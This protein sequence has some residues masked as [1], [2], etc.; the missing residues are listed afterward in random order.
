MRLQCGDFQTNGEIPLKFACQGEDVSPALAWDGVPREAASLALLC[1][2][3]DAPGGMWVHWVAFDLPANLTGLPE[4]VPRR[5]EIPGGGLQGVNDFG[6]PG[7]GGPCPPFGPQHRYFF[8][9]YALDRNVNLGP[10]ASRG[11]L[12][13]AMEGHVLAQC[14]L[15]GRYQRR[16]G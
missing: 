13:K 5:A 2:D 3:P 6:R 10:Q 7:Y 8:R 9:L 14:E 12:L 1:E 15:M 16:P 4:A 11:D